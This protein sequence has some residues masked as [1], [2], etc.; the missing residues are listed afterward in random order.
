[1]TTLHKTPSHDTTGQPEMQTASNNHKKLRVLCLQVLRTLGLFA[2]LGAVNVAWAA[3]ST[4]AIS[5]NPAQPQ[6]GKAF[7][8]VATVT[9][10]RG[11]PTGSVTFK[12]QGTGA[13]LGT[14]TLNSSGVAQLSQTYNSQSSV[15]ITATYSGDANY[16]ASSATTTVLIYPASTTVAINFSPSPGNAGTQFTITAVISGGYQPTGTMSFYYGSTLISNS[17]TV[18]TDASGYSRAVFAYGLPLPGNYSFTAVYSGDANNNSSTSAPAVQSVVANATTTSVA[19]NPN[20]SSSGQTTTLTAQISNAYNPAGTVTFYDGTTVLGTG[21][22]ANYQASMSYAFAT[23]GAHSLKAVYSGDA[24]NS[25]STSSVV[26]QTVKPASATSLSSSLNPS[27]A[28]QPTTLSATV[29]GASGTPTGTVTFYDGATAIGTGTLNAGGVATL[30]YAFVAAGSHSLTASYGGDVTYGPS[31]STALAQ[32]V[33]KAGSAASLTSNL[34][35]SGL[36]ASVILTAT[37]TGSLP[38]GTVTFYDG[39]TAL[40]TGGVYPGGMA[41]LTYAFTTQGPHTLTAAYSGDANNLASTSA[42]YTQNAGMTASTTA[43][44]S[45]ANPGAPNQGILLT[46]TVTGNVPSGRVTFYDG[47][48]AIG[49]G[50]IGAGGTAT[51]V[52]TFPALGAHTLTAAY[53]GDANNVASTSAPY[54]QTVA[55]AS[56]TVAVSSSANPNAFNQAVLLTAAIGGSSP[57]GTVTFYDGATAIGSGTVSFGSASVFYTF[58]AMGAHSITASYSGDANNNAATSAAYAQTVG[59]ANTNTA[60]SLSTASAAANQPVTLTATVAGINPTGT[61]TFYDG[62]SALGSATLTNG[63]ASFSQ[64]FAA[65]GNHSLTASYSGD[66]ANSPGISPIASLGVAQAATVYYVQPDHLDTPRSIIDTT[67]NVVWAWDNTDPFGANVPN[68]NPSNQGQFSFNLRFPGQYADKETTL[69]YNV[70]RSY[71]PAT[72]RYIESDPIGLGGGVNTFAYVGGDPL[73]ASDPLGL[74]S[75]SEKTLEQALKRALATEIAG[76]GPEDPAADV[77]A[78]IVIIGTIVLATDEI[79]S[80]NETKEDSKVVPFPKAKEKNQCPKE[81]DDP[82]KKMRE[83]LLVQYNSLWVRWHGTRAVG[84]QITLIQEARI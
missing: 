69:Y 66:A 33:N 34:N 78:V 63:S 7:Y 1:M 56:P 2:L 71:D 52:Y 74:L 19:A 53:S 55:K 64:A 80:K 18:I 82:C 73:G 59:A 28:G 49:S 77:A 8:L 36:G 10:K 70:N 65:T 37:V 27:A 62:T 68:E 48:T 29:T 67:G 54:T 46:A 15:N 81:E 42:A 35:P 50:A 31:S 83:A 75:L 44:T 39:A 51:L 60:L 9:G 45:S 3:A 61:V 21:S 32:T 57:T 43:L 12:N 41:T 79:A 4:T 58:P 84:G 17:T 20:P 5:T 76:G 30:S 40:G 24:A 13:I 38:S 47:A 14:A 72:G 25:G 16:T 23:T 6:I 26:T 22:V 11:T